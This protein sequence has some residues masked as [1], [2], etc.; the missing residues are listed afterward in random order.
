MFFIIRN[1]YLH[2]FKNGM[3][4]IS[5]YKNAHGAT[6]F[7]KMVFNDVIFKVCHTFNLPIALKFVKITYKFIDMLKGIF[8]VLILIQFSACQQ[9]GPFSPI[10]QSNCTS[11]HNSD[12]RYSGSLGPD[13][14]GTQRDV[15][16]V[17]IKFGTYPQGYKPKRTTHI[18]PQFNLTEK[19][20][21]EIYYYLNQ[22]N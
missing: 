12:P 2:I 10:Y 5:N 14:F 3:F 20:I 19:Q 15:L 8:S 21:D 13:L 18:M 9:T 6:R 1:C 22:K 11:C 7:N 17:K 16:S 4:R